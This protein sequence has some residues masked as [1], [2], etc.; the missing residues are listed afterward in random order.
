MKSRWIPA[1]AVLIPL[2][3]AGCSGGGGGAPGGA[4]GAYIKQSDVI[5]TDVFAKAKS[6]GKGKDQ[7]T[8][9]KQA[10]LWQDA[11]TRLKALPMPG[12]SVE[13]ARQFVTDTENLS[14]A[15]TAAAR[16]IAAGNQAKATTYFGQADT[17]KKEAAKTAKEYGYVD[18]R[19]IND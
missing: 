12:E 19:T 8:A 13:L 18:C 3:V 17:I 16:S 4:K 10:D 7:E 9:Q 2:T 6:I 5:C 1:V 14:L 11:N 15:Y